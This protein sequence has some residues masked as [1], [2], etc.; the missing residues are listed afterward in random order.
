MFSGQNGLGEGTGIPA[1]IGVILL[2]QGK[3]TTH[4]VLPPEACIDPADF[5][6]LAMQAMKARPASGSAKQ[7]A[8]LL[9]ETIE[10]DGS[11]HRMEM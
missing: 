7:A 3:I 11:V 10:P 4:G 1:A 5:L 6:P 9:F 8:S 2:Q